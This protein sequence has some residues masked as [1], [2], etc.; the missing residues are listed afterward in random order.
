MAEPDL[1]P[2][3]PGGGPDEAPKRPKRRRRVI[4]LVLVLL[5]VAVFCPKKLSWLYWG[6]GIV[7]CDYYFDGP[8]E[9]GGR[10]HRTTTRLL[11]G[12]DPEGFRERLDN[13]WVVWTG[14]SHSIFANVLLSVIPYT[15]EGEA[16]KYMLAPYRNT[17]EFSP[18]PRVL[19]SE[20]A[21]YLGCR[22]FYLRFY[23]L[24]STLSELAGTEDW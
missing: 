8:R 17:L 10:L 24:N 6:Q 22:N 13:T 18:V 3:S 21:I 9:D 5:A 2:D 16:E 4:L 14:W 12:G 20:R 15:E 7:R 11:P 1:P 19:N 23:C